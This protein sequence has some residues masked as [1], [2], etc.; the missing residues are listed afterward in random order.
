MF[1]TALLTPYVETEQHGPNYPEPPP[2][3]IEGEPEFEVEQ[4]VGSRRVG[5]KRTLEYRVRWKGY[6]SAHDSWEPAK[7]VRAP[8]LIKEYQLRTIERKIK[9]SHEPRNDTNY[10]ASS[11]IL[12]KPSLLS[13]HWAYEDLTEGAF[14]VTNQGT[15][16]AS[17]SGNHT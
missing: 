1:H 6:S 5:R 11:V 10:Q 7:H 13:H 3:I 4:I 9:S 2:D 16:K 17:L 8:E 12:T 14:S 15:D